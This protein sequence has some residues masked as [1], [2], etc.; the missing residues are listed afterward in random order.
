MTDMQSNRWQHCAVAS[1]C[2]S[3]SLSQRTANE[4]N[5]VSTDHVHGGS[6]NMFKNRIDTYLVRAGYAYKNNF[7][8]TLDKPEASLS[9]AL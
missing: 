5:K 3:Y 9:A 2:T 7:V 4:W 8:W 6:V 1:R